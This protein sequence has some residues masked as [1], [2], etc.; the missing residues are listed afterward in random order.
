MA[1]KRK[2]NAFELNTHTC[3]E[4]ERDFKDSFTLNFGCSWKRKNRTCVL[5]F[6][7]W[8]GNTWTYISDLSFLQPRISTDYCL[9]NPNAYSFVH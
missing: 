3:W 6:Q 5:H 2:I 1:L 9:I 8:K 7:T 4:N